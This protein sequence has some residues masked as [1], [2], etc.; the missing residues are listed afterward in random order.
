[1]PHTLFFFFFVVVPIQTANFLLCCVCV[2]FGLYYI[3]NKLRFLMCIVA[4]WIRKRIKSFGQI[5]VLWGSLLW[6]FNVTIRF[7]IVYA[8]T[9]FIAL[10]FGI[11]NCRSKFEENP[12]AIYYGH[13]QWCV[14]LWC[15]PLMC[16]LCCYSDAYII[17]Y[18]L[19]V[20]KE[21]CFFLSFYICKF[22]FLFSRFFS[23]KLKSARLF[24]VWWTR[25]IHHC[26][27][28]EWFFIYIKPLQNDLFKL[29]SPAFKHLMIALFTTYDV[30]TP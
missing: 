1:M 16:E 9:P 3:Q 4:P 8:H 20:D 29:Y 5:N 2:L 12:T 22:G 27:I 10:E 13:K 7:S 18:G 30:Q 15:M 25:W 19:C 17:W 23:C 21:K 26:K 6:C 11:F 24:I 14:T 28:S